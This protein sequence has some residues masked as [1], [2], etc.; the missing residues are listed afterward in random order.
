MSLTKRSYWFTVN[1]KFVKILQWESP[2]SGERSECNKVKL[3]PRTVNLV[4]A[5]RWLKWFNANI[6]LS[7]KWQSVDRN[8]KVE[9]EQFHVKKVK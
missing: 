2:A 7:S 5:T 6:I 8:Y 1:T 4:I 9:N 3:F